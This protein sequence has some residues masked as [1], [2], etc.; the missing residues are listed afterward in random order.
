MNSVNNHTRNKFLNDK[1]LIINWEF[2]WEQKK[3]VFSKV[4]ETEEKIIEV[5]LA[6]EKIKKNLNASQDVGQLVGEVIKKI[7]SNKYILKAPT[8]TRY[9]VSVQNAVKKNRI[10]QNTRVALDSSTLTIMKLLLNKTDPIIDTML[11]ENP[12][13]V[14]YT[15]I[16][17]LGKQLQQLKEV[18]ELPLFN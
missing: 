5:D 10:K 2:L 11:N 17:G 4:I 18:V 16:G 3:K 1:D 14:N 9:I 15:D 6:E 7:S 8:G 12:G 13:V